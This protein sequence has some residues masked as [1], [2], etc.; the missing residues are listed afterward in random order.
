MSKLQVTR[1]KLVEMYFGIQTIGNK[2][3]LPFKLT[4]ALTK[5]KN[6]LKNEYDA[7]VE[8]EKN[9]NSKEFMEFEEKRRALCNEYADKDTSGN[10]IIDNNNFVITTNKDEFDEKVTAL[11]IEFKE[12]LD[13][14][15]SDAKE[16]NETF[17]LETIEVETFDINVDLL[18]NIDNISISELDSVL[19][20]LKE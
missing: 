17:M 1:K 15:I 5:N 19:E 4:Y 18:S 20:L 6:I 3:N 7:I 16:F 13:K 11:N 2:P 9:I 8:T 14:R 10:A 12:V